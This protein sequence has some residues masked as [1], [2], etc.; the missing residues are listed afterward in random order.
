MPVPIEIIISNGEHRYRCCI[1][2]GGALLA[3]VGSYLG[4]VPNIFQVRYSLG[5]P[6]LR[7]SNNKRKRA[8]E[9]RIRL[10]HENL[11][12]QVSLDFFPALRELFLRFSSRQN[13]Y[14]D[15]RGS[16]PSYP[17]EN[18]KSLLNGDTSGPELKTLTLGWSKGL[19]KW[20]PRCAINDQPSSCEHAVVWAARRAVPDACHKQRHYGGPWV[21]RTKYG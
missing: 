7:A 15:S 18:I 20:V 16:F 19:L 6:I 9:R 10:W 21:R 4:G 17:R 12:I 13:Y 1:V 8:W 11:N 5:Y 3:I 14:P 2:L